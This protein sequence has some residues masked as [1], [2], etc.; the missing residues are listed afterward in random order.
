MYPIQFKNILKH[1]IWGGESI[2]KKLGRENSTNDLLIGESWDICDREEDQSIVLNGEFKGL[3][4]QELREQHGKIFG[5]KFNLSKPFPIL[6][7]IL[8]AKQDLSLQVHPKKSNLSQLSSDSQPKS[9]FWYIL[10]HEKNS[11]VMSGLNKDSY[12]ATIK[13]KEDFIANLNSPDLINFVNITQTQKDKLIYV[14]S[15]TIHAIGAGNLILEIQENSDTTYRV[16]DWGRV[17]ANSKPRDLH[18]SES[19]ICID[20]KGEDQAL[21]NDVDT[22]KDYKVVDSKYFETYSYAIKGE[23]SFNTTS[24][25]CVLLSLTNGNISVECDFEVLL[26]KGDTIL[27][28]ADQHFKITNKDNTPANI[29][30]TKPKY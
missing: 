11:K 16:S 21:I 14:E 7:K 8:D 24:E 5:S 18:I 23:N 20:F 3:T 15:G 30:I 6:V 27:L 10:D 22:T 29:L 9:E 1:R 26:K 28:P 17:D 19:L 2:T 4:I 12:T 25:T 13:F